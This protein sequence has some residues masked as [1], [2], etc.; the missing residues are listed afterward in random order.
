MPG[1]RG[2]RRGAIHRGITLDGPQQLMI[3]T[4]GAR[5]ESD[6]FNAYRKAIE[7]A[8]W[9]GNRSANFATLDKGAGIVRRLHEAGF[10]VDLDPAVAEAVH[11]AVDA[12]RAAVASAV[13][14]ADAVEAILKAKG[15]SLFSFQRVGSTWLSSRYRALLADEMGWETL[16]TLVALP[17]GARAV[18]VAPAVVKGVW[19]REA[20][21]WR[22]DL[23]T[24]VLTGRGSFRWPQRDGESSSR[25]TTSCA[26]RSRS[27]S[28]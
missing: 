3:Q 24:T 25:T 18:V 26:P 8:K 22:P 9:D 11:G 7:G 1:L 20:A 23:S 10:L 14:N 28:P 15:L 5:L 6:K 16:Q 19:K 17:A 4:V 2:H 13:L 12:N 27:W 21:R